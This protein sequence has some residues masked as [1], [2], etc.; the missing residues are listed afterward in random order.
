MQ[1]VI[2]GY[3]DSDKVPGFYAET[4][5]GASGI[6]LGTLPFIL[7]IVGLKASS[8]GTLTN[9]VDVTDIFSADDGATL[10]GAGGE[11][12]RMCRAVFRQGAGGARIK[13]C[14]PAPNGA[15][16][17]GTATITIVISGSTGS[18]GTHR[19][20][21]AG[22]LVEYNPASGLAQ[23]AYATALAAKINTYPDLPVTASA[24]TNVV[25]LTSKSLTVRAGDIIVFSEMVVTPTNF[26]SQTLAGG[27][28]VT[29]GGVRLVNG[30]G[31]ESLTNILALLEPARY[32]RIAL[33]NNDAT[34]LAL[35]EAHIDSKAGVLQGRM[36]HVVV[37]SNGS[38]AAAT[39]LAQTTL[40]N[41]RFQMCWML[42]SES[43]PSE[44]AAAMAALRASREQTTPNSGYDGVVLKGIVPQR[45]RADWANRATQQAALD[46][47]LT[48]LA[49][50]EEGTVTI[51]RS[52]TTRS[53]D[54]ST[55]DYR[56]LDTA[57]AVV[58]D[59]G[60]DRLRLV[61]GSEFLPANPYVRP[62]PAASEPDPPEGQAYPLLWTKR[63]QSELRLMER[64]NILTQTDPEL[65]P[66]HAPQSE[67]NAAAKRIMSA[68]P[69]TPLPIQ[70]AIGVSVRQTGVIA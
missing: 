65:Y 11:G 39:S 55:P 36:E 13:G 1:I 3:S 20:W 35:W 56:T 58:P 7:L 28:A 43:H 64:E 47:G 22:D 24:N 4:K 59:Y 46:A 19:V 54:G 17:A 6:N 50:T 67:W 60:R 70:H 34:N 14:A 53:L 2:D 25:T 16:V 41:H 51:V 40:N 31:V 37:A 21:I 66:S 57:E 23:N 48:A 32:H 45:K 68:V 44:V 12:A 30:A 8:G 42:N 29:G 38:L 33:S 26:T 10:W 18:T 15:A 49:T 63:V 61:W 62:D 5:F 69:M 27:T 52:I 9:D